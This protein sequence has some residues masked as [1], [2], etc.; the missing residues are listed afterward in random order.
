[1]KNTV[2]TFKKAKE[3]GTKLTML[4]A[5][6]YSTARLMDEA[7]VNSILVG[8]S[9]GNVIL[10]YEDTLSVTIEDMI[11]HCAAVSRGAKNALVV[12]DMPFMSYEVSVEEALK[13]AGRLMKEGRANAVKLE[14]GEE[15]VPQV[16]AMVNAG[17]PVVGHLGLTP[18]AVNVLGGNRIQGKSVE[19]ARKLIKDAKALEEAGA[20]AIVLECIPGELASI[21]TK[22]VSVPTIGIGAGA[23][24]DGQVLVYQ[25]MLGISG[26]KPK[27]C[28][29]YAQIG[30]IMKEAFASYIRETQ[31]GVFPS[32]ENTFTVDAEV[33][34]KLY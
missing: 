14:G 15:Y 32:E 21:I 25:D 31:E 28:K 24:C 8:D 19:A 26:F 6:D 20:F 17:I 7:G 33:L 10:G 5:Y 3:E 16:R 23:G 4:T 9:L 29:Q 18:Q 30:E 2:L 34:E 22:E 27:F 13:N 1:V 12:C 11:H